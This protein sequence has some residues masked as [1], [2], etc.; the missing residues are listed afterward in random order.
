MAY[1]QEFYRMYRTYL[2]E[3][4]VRTNHNRIFELFRKFTQHAQ[5]Q[6]VDLGCGLG[7]YSTYGSYFDYVGV[8]VNNA[9]TVKNFLRADYHDLGFVGSL[10]FMPTAFVSLFSIE[11]CHSAKDKYALYEKLFARIPSIQNA[12]VGGFFYKSKRELETVGEAG[13][14]VSYQTI[15]DPSKHISRTFSEL[16]IHF[17]TPSDMFGD[18]VVEVWKILGRW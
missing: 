14:I 8:D 5:L 17:D 2:C 1:D 16:R 10:P 13:G 4:A 7:E 12:L 11:C 18:D 6:V 15:E 3:L 9:G